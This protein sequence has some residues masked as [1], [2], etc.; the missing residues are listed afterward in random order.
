MCTV[1]ETKILLD[2]QKL[3]ILEKVDASIQNRINHQKPSSE[4]RKQF[5]SLNINMAKIEK[6]LE[7]IKEGFKKNKEE[8]QELYKAMKDFIDS[9]DN[10]YSGRWVEKVLIWG[11][12]VVGTGIIGALLS[13]ILK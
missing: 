13:L 1:K 9:A 10:K 2:K 11:G 5:N 6:D 3:D 12:A 7:Y 8:H 4:T